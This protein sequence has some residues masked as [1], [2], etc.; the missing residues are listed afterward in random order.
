[1]RRASPGPAAV[2]LLLMVAPAARAELRAGAARAAIELPARVPLA[3]YSRRGGKPSIGAHDPV[4]VRALVLDDGRQAAAIVSCDLLI[5]DERLAEAARR[6]L[7]ADGRPALQLFLAATHTHSGPGAYGRRFAEQL[8][9][10]HYDDAVFQAIVE[11]ISRAVAAAAAAEQPVTGAAYGARDTMDL[12]KNRMDARGLIA[13]DLVLHALY[14]ADRASPLAVVASFAAH[15]TT[16]G[17]DNRELSA[18]YPGVLARDVERGAPGTVC[19]F[20]AGSVGDQAPVKH[21]AGFDSTE[22]LGHALAEA[23]LAWLQQAQPAPVDGLQARRDLMRLDAPQLRLGG[24]H[25]P[26]WLGRRL[27]DDDA[28]LSLLAIGDTLYAGAPCDLA[29][30]LGA[31]LEAAARARGWRPVVASFVED[32]I[33]YC[34]PAEAF[35]GRNYETQMSFNGPHT[36]ER[37]VGRLTELLEGF[38]RP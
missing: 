12:V 13:R 17:A 32:Y 19:L 22:H 29:A 9:M 35:T 33:G 23:T 21:G 14:G 6:R 4:A 37:I 24:W 11:A 16:L 36:G 18:E 10:G 28:T 34:V 26:R 3:G 1:M 38:T 25:L 27:V 8:S 31:R 15:P 5:I 7:A 2:A 20:L 30:P